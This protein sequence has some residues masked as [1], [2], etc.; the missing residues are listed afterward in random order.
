MS[1][2]TAITLTP[3]A[4]AISAALAPNGAAQAQDSDSAT[5]DEIIV[6]A[7]KRAENVQ[8]IPASIQAITEATLNKIGASGIEDY[9]RFIPAVNVVSYRPG[10]TDVVFRGVH[11]GGV[12]GGL[13]VSP[14]SIYVD[15]IS[16]TTTSR[17]Q[18]EVRIH[19]INR[20]EALDGP[21]GTL[22]GGSAQS[23]TL[24]II[25]NQP[26]PSQFEGTVDVTLKQGPDTGFSHDVGGV[27]N[28]PFADGRAAIRLT[29]FT[30]LD[31]G[32]IDNVFGHTPDTFFGEPIPTWGQLDNADVVE[33]DYN[34]VDYSGA[35]AALRWEFNDAWAVTVSHMFQDMKADGVHHYDPFAG[36]LKVVK[37]LPEGSTD[38]WTVSALVIEGDI[39]WAQLTSATS[40]F[41]RKT[42]ETRDNTLYTKYFQAFSCLPQ[43]DP[44]IYTEYFVDPATGNAISYPRYCFGP[45]S[46]DDMLID[47]QFLNSFETFAQEFRLTGGGERLDWIVGLFYEKTT[48]QWNEIWG[49]PTTSSYQDSLSLA[50]WQAMNGSDFG[51]D[52]TFGWL[53]NSETEWEQTAVFGEITWRFTDRWTA[54]LGGRWFDRDSDSEYF[55]NNPGSELNEE[56]VNDGIAVSAGGADDFVP[57]VNISY[58][59]DTDKMMYVL[60]SEGFR[61][62]GTNRGRGDPILPRTF[63][64]DKLKNTELGIKT[65]WANERVRFNLTYYD[66]EWEDFQVQVVDPTWLTGGVW[67]Q[68]VA[69]VGSAEVTGVQVELDWLLSENWSIGA[70]ATSLNSEITN[71]IDLDGDP[72]S[73]E[74]PSGTRLPDSPEIKASAWLDYN[75]ETNFI[76]GQGF[77]RLQGSHNGGVLNRFAD[78]EE[79]DN[80]VHPLVET[81]SYTIWDFRIGMIMD[82]GWQVDLFAKNLTDERAEYSHA[83]LGEL[84]FSSVQDGRAGFNRIYINRPREFGI[85]IR[86]SWTR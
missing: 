39:G 11:S 4:A 12:F 64:A 37:F 55:V 82:N 31:A 68:V 78:S 76:P 50:Y 23:G 59:M 2:K 7:T 1:D 15:E 33:D 28:I 85:Q 49:R 81:P 26:D 14:S 84:P 69:N 41:D 44:A 58:E 51:A 6:T 40:Y 19:D 38:D 53:E 21:Q 34:D 35:R 75:W 72:D 20:V 80:P 3:L 16:V 70:N 25:T 43:L 52:A 27:V 67:Q 77:A 86:K 83:S 36:D 32:F 47:A 48:D 63:E 79:F 8:D 71:D 13:F 30:A 42:D 54:N 56:F 46:L 17:S 74:I 73:V 10:S 22:F 60:Y 61:P 9:S 62:G 65:L 57:K 24:R 18:P 66:M 45:S 29:G 5:L